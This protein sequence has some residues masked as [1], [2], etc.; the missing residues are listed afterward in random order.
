VAGVPKL[1]TSDGVI[2]HYEIHRRNPDEPNRGAIVLLHGLSQQR[3]FW[4]PVISALAETDGPPIVVVDQRG[5]GDSDSTL[6]ADYSINRCAEDIVEVIGAIDASW[7]SVVGH[8]WGASVA[9]RAAAALGEKCRS[10][11]LID[12][13]VFGPAMLGEP[14]IVREQLRPPLLGL[15]LTDIFELMRSGDLG[16]F[17]TPE[18]EDALRPTFVVDDQGLARTRIGVERHMAVLD[19]L[20]GYSPD[21]DLETLSAAHHADLWVV[22]CSPLNPHVGQGLGWQAIQ[23]QAIAKVAQLVPTARV[24]E[25]RGAIHDVPLQWPALVGGLIRSASTMNPA[26]GKVND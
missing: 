12:G 11:V 15:P 18:V 5:H 9:L 4:G 10:V 20:F 16:D 21:L 8:S 22:N 17:W 6:S 2:I 23:G 25:W 1:T 7:V 26:E 3:H 14:E 24:L 19:G 13:G